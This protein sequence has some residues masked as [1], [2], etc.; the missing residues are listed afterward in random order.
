LYIGVWSKWNHENAVNR[1]ATAI[2]VCYHATWLLLPLK[3]VVNRWATAIEVF[4]AR[5]V[6]FC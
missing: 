5:G 2:E 1:W 3:F 6:K 4:A